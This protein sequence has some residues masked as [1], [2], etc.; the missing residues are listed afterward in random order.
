MNGSIKSRWLV[1]TG[2]LYAVLFTVASVVLEGDA[3]GEKTSG[4]DVVAYFNGHQGRTMAE[5]FAAPALAAL[6]ILFVSELRA[7]AQDGRANRALPTAM[8][9][10]AVVWAGG[11][12]LGAAIGLGLASS[13]DHN[14]PQVAQT[15]NVLNNADWI[16]FIG[17]VA[18]FLIGAGASVIA[19]GWL[20]KWLGWVALV[21]GVVS[22]AGPGGFIGFFLAPLWMLVA[23]ILLATR[24]S[25][26]GASEPNGAVH[27]QRT[28]VP[29]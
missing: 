11:I 10:G 5:A 24:R 26:A 21:G 27:G 14:Q 20:P 2:P 8:M 13:A 25:D 17:G 4:A 1:W 6:L 23:G 22:L 16:P 28:A 7:R 12:M 18:I 19:S 29:S 15:L 9:A 3:P